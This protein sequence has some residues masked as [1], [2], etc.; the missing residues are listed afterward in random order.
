MNFKTI[1]ALLIA[2]SFLQTTSASEFT[3]GPTIEKFGK[4]ALVESADQLQE[5]QIF[6]VVFDVAKQGETDKPNRSIDSLARFINMHVRAGVK[7][8]NISLALV[9]HGKA[10]NDLISNKA[11]EKKFQT[12]NPNHA[13]INELLKN[14]TQIFLCGQSATYYEINKEDLHHGVQLSL[15]AMTAH[16]LLQQQGYTLNPF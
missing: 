4:N 15:S 1:T 7:P 11:Y 3:S 16:A 6:K 8:E 12:D 5:E 10:S 9:V 13:L 2:I 14:R